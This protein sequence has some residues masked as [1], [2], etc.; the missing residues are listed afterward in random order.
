MQSGNKQFQI[1]IIFC[2][3]NLQKNVKSHEL[4]IGSPNHPKCGNHIPVV[5][6]FFLKNG[7][8]LSSK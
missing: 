4:T 5:F 7:Q 6:N 1:Y 8:C 2:V 3:N